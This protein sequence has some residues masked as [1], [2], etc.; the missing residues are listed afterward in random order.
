MTTT[1]PRIKVTPLTYSQSCPLLLT[2]HRPVPRLCKQDIDLRLEPSLRDT[3]YMYHFRHFLCRNP[4]ALILG[5]FM[6]VMGLIPMNVVKPV[7]CA[8]FMP[9]MQAL[10]SP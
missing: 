6:L 9:Y 3:T 8:S 2:V 1:V 5:I 10:P 4:L 7:A